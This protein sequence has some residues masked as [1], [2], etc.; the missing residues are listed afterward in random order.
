[1]A[2]T[3]CVAA[4]GL[5]LPLMLLTQPSLQLWLSQL[6]VRS[7]ASRN[8]LA[9]SQKEIDAGAELEWERRYLTTLGVANKRL[10]EMRIQTS[11]AAFQ[12]AEVCNCC[13]H[14]GWLCS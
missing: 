10:Y 9:V 8:Q 14:N 7:Y 12:K 1:M 2:C 3:K 5:A 6:C 4:K 13:A 11:A